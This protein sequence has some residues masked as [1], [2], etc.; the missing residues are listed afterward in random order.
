MRERMNVTPGG[1]PVT[2]RRLELMAER[3]RTEA[4]TRAATVLLNQTANAAEA[5]RDVPTVNQDASPEL[6][7]DQATSP[8]KGAE[9]ATD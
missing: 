2:S 7:P 9:S 3:N 8:S 6:Q 5:K 1:A 4:D